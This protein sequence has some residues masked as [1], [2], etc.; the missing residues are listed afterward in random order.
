MESP[1]TGFDPAKWWNPVSWDGTISIFNRLVTLTQS[2][3]VVPDLCASPP[4][5]NASHT[6]YTFRL[7]QGVKFQHGREVTADDA[8]FSLERLVNPKTASEGSSLYTSLTIPGMEQ[9]QNEKTNVLSGVKVIDKYTLEIELEEPDSV[10]LY[11]LCMPFASIVPRDVVEAKSE[12][13]WNLAPI[14]TGPFMMSDVNLNSGLTMTKNPNYSVGAAPYLDRVQWV[15]GVDPELSLLRIQNGQ[16]DMMNET[17]PG[18]QYPSLKG[19]PRTSKLIVESLV[20]DC[21]YITLSL[22]HPAMKD[23]RVRKAIAMA[24]D[25]DR[26]LR[27]LG[28][29]GAVGSGG[30]F[31]PRSP[32]FQPGLAYTYDP[33][34]AKQLL[35][36]AG[37]SNG[38][39]VT[40]WS[41]NFSPFSNI[42]QTVPQ[43]LAK[44]GI[45]VTPQLMPMSAWDAEVVKNPAGIT[46][47]EWPLPYPHGSYV[48]DGGFTKAALSEGCCNFSDWVSPSFDTLA[49][50]AHRVFDPDQ[51]VTMYKEMDRIVTREQAL[52]VPMDY[53]ADAFLVSEKV[54]NYTTL[55]NTPDPGTHFFADYWLET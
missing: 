23:L 37:Y 16:Q 45:R 34:Q 51:L 39:D 9:M 53:P 55:P 36:S 46:D 5:A 17:I 3:Q 13:S 31:S 49:A 44:V 10:F 12:T 26:L 27:T 32:Y 54:R 40:F 18:A 1:P 43:D 8:K 35:D 20:S 42:A 7:K 52:W 38:F 28:G 6:R 2:F 4:Q 25:K 50:E 29:L 30:I 19:D 48:M 14:G 24:V 11:V 22:K 41:G 33:A 15:I 21:D 47:N